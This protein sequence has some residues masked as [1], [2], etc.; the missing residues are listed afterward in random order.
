MTAEIIES[1]NNNFWLKCA[2]SNL[3]SMLDEMGYT[4]QWVTGFQ[5]NAL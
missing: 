1:K 5:K 2:E 3:A 4:K